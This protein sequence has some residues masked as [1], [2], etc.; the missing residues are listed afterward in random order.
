[1]EV[2]YD[3]KEEGE[4]NIKVDIISALEELRKERNKKKSLKVELKMKEGSHY[5]NFEELE[6]VITSLKNKIEE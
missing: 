3:S 4:V 6:Q 2:E 5:S 1:M